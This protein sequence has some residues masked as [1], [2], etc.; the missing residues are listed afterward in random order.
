MLRAA[1]VGTGYW[2]GYA[3]VPGLRALPDTEVVACVGRTIDSARR[4]ADDFG[5][6]S[7]FPTIEAL[8]DSGRAARFIVIA[9]PDDMHPSAATAV[10]DAAVPVFC[11]KPL[12][13]D[14]ATAL[15]LADHAT[16]RGVPNTVGYSF[17]YSPA[18]QALRSDLESGWLGDPWLVEITEH[19]AQFHPAL[20]KPMNW[21]GDPTKATAGALFEYGSHAIDLADW[22]VGPIE[23]RLDESVACTA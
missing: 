7:V 12:A 10:I 1:V 2:A 5:I 8:L 20:G 9:G 17:R 4:F 6:P 15:S 11:E 13:N 14:A 16:E 22:L 18:I 19:N 3:H 21:K 23:C